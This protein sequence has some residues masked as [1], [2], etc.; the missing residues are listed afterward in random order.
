MIRTAPEPGAVRKKRAVS[1]I[2]RYFIRAAEFRSRRFFCDAIPYIAVA[3]FFRAVLTWEKTSVRSD[4]FRSAVRHTVDAAKRKF[5]LADLKSIALN[6]TVK[7]Q[8]LLIHGKIF[9]RFTAVKQQRKM[10]GYMFP[11]CY[12]RRKVFEKRWYILPVFFIHIAADTDIDSCFRQQVDIVQ[13]TVIRL[14]I[15]I[16]VFPLLIIRFR[17]VH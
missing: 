7:I 16:I 12:F 10:D 2:F 15:D 3:C 9:R 4:D 1:A 11:V 13:D 14:I 8:N 17:S 5:R 6:H